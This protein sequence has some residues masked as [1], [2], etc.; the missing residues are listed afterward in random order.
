MKKKKITPS[1]KDAFNKASQIA[2]RKA[3]GADLPVAILENGN[4]YYLYRDGR[5]KKVVRKN[6]ISKNRKQ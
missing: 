5:K 2:R 6:L 4:I 3:F 1:E